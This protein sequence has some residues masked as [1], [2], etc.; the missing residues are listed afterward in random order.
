MQLRNIGAQGLGFKSS[1]HLASTHHI[2]RANKQLSES[3]PTDLSSDNRLL[4]RLNRTGGIQ[5]DRPF[6]QP[7]GCIGH[8]HCDQGISGR[9]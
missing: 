6:N 2:P 7:H 8:R 9:L 4:P 1:Q 5:M 3:N